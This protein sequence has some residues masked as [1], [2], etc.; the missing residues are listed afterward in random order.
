MG[1]R[2]LPRQKAVKRRILAVAA[3]SAV[4][5]SGCFLGG[6]ESDDNSTPTAQPPTATA[7]TPTPIPT[8]S[9]T[10]DPLA[11]L[12]TTQQEALAWLKKALEGQEA[13]A[14]PEKLQV[15]KVLCV[16][17]NLDGDG[18]QDA[19]YL[20]PVK[21]PTSQLPHPAAVFI[22]A[23]KSQKFGELA[24]DLTADGSPLGL[25]FFAIAERS[26]DALADLAY[27]KITCGATTCSSRAVV[28]S[29]DGT[30]WR[31]IASP[32]MTSNVDLISWKGTGAASELKIHGGKLPAT[33]P[34]D[35]GP[36]RAATISY[37]LKAARYERVSI[38]RDDPE[39]LYHAIEDADAMFETDRLAAVAAYRAAIAN[40]AL[41]DWKLRDDQPDRR[42]A[43]IGYA[44]WR[45]ALATAVRGDDP[46]AALDEVIVRN[47]EPLFDNVA[48]VFRTGFVE[49]DGVI[50]GC[51]AVN[52]YL[53]TPIEGTNTASYIEQ[54]FNYGYANPPGSTWVEKICPF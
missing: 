49:G 53:T 34:S 24:I 10:P 19:A 28:L 45:I 35:A 29:W 51:A 25:S 42:P 27:L 30:E 20:V 3:T 37:A 12:P 32:E 2:G 54:R 15:G 21:L 50:A 46:T 40:T 26:G 13:P 11:Q 38:V 33:A 16:L 17:G 43:L 4:L 52:L 5:L 36:S 18:V 14:C 8:P 7:T 23:G 6:G 1:S 47:S 44:F 41:K 22:W 31:D 48:D 39:Y 9:P